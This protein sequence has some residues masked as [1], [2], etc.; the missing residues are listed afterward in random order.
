M[1]NING[2]EGCLTLGKSHVSK[3][4]ANY[5]VAGTNYLH[6]QEQLSASSACVLHR[7]GSGQS[8]RGISETWNGGGFAKLEFLQYPFPYT[9]SRRLHPAG[10]GKQTYPE[11][12]W[13]RMY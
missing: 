12:S 4:N 8:K 13:R 10:D 6:L 11:L 2:E 5:E 7:R 1:S 3:K 9:H